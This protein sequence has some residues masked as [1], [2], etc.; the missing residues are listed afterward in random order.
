VLL[1]EVSMGRV[2]RERTLTIDA[3]EHRLEARR[4]GYRSASRLIALAA[5]DDT[6]VELK[7]LKLRPVVLASAGAARNSKSSPL[8]WAGWTATSAFAVGAG[9]TFAVALSS[10]KH[11]ADLRE[12]PSST[13]DERE[14]AAKRAR[15]FAIA[16]D[17]L[18]GAALV[19]GGASLY[20]SLRG[21]SEKKAPPPGATTQIG[22]NG[23][24]LAIT[25]HY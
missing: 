5:G 24:G 25:R 1:D 18:A 15:T 10:A 12:S 8:V 9:A 19:A 4:A 20:F 14:D 11:L 13:A 17:V 16:S 6:K 7:L 23:L 3:G 21:S 22:L 2:E